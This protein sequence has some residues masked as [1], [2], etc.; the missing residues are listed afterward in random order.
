MSGITT[1]KQFEQDHGPCDY[2]GLFLGGSYCGPG[3]VGP[4]KD[5]FLE[6]DLQFQ[7]DGS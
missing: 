2:R 3:G 5:V 4:P 1:K 6:E 7:P